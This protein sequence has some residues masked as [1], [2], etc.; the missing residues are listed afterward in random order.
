MVRGHPRLFLALI[1]L[2]I[3]A[4]ISGGCVLGRGPVRPAVAIL[5]PQNGQRLTA[6]QEV[7]V[8]SVALDTRGIDHIELWVDGVRVQSVSPGS[9]Q[10]PTSW[11]VSL[12][13]TPEA[14]GRHQLAVQAVNRAG[15]AS[16]PFAIVVDVV[17]AEAASMP[18][19]PTPTL[20]PPPTQEQPSPTPPPAL[21]LNNATF[22]A[23]ITVPDETPFRPG[24][25]FEKIWRMRNSGTCPWDNRYAWTFESGEAMTAQRAVAVPPTVPGAD[26]DIAV[27]MTAPAQPG[28]Y[29]GR[30]RM[31]GPDGQPF[32]QRATVIIVVIPAGLTPPAAPAQLRAAFEPPDI[33]VL[34]WIDQA[35]N[36]LGVR[37]YTD[38][39][40]TLL[41]EI[42]TPDVT[43]ARIQHVPCGQ[44]VRFVVKTYN[45]AGESEPGA[46]VTFRTPDCAAGLPVIHYFTAE[47]AEILA[48]QKALLRWDLE[49]AREAR[50]FPGGEAGV[51]APGEMEVSPTQTTTYRLVAVNELG[52]VEAR[53]TVTVREGSAG[54]PIVRMTVSPDTVGQGEP[55]RITVSGEAE[56]GLN[57][58]WWWG[59]GTGDAELDAVHAYP[60]QG[61]GQCTH[62]WDVRTEISGNLRFRAN[63]RSN[64]GVQADQGGALPSAQVRVIRVLA[65]ARDLR[66]SGEGC[67]D[68]ESAAVGECGPAADIRYIYDA[69]DGWIVQGV[70]GTQVAAM[71]IQPAIE[72]VSYQDV[73]GTAS[74]LPQAAVGPRPGTATPIHTLVAVR[75]G[76]SRFGK[77]F[78]RADAGA[79]LVEVLTYAE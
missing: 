41:A 16:A 64:A 63:A 50:I 28:H 35:D 65:R 67:L 23:D 58:I 33:V 9:S 7:E 43:E 2:V 55:F 40:R 49:G 53:V 17:P 45:Q 59:E 72:A 37:I 74:W 8:R 22:V 32:G 42:P 78:F 68:L 30:W 1:G 47:P 6:G 4:V 52:T 60:C 54:V 24:D 48:G 26:A 61:A 51:I 77:L 14:A 44:E 70:N 56:G 20:T 71:G 66:V 69:V 39:G 79:L 46:S 15:V 73:R 62:S 18:A 34:R 29:I 21:C 12:R 36:E 19:T 25:T 13:W 75:T 10:E 38:E 11:E 3:T 31:Q 27:R 76:E 57:S 5:A